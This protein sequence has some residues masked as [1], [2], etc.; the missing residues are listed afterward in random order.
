MENITKELEK[1]LCYCM[2]RTEVTRADIDA[3]C[4]TQITNHIFEMVNAVAE[5]DPA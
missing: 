1:L 4:I 3:V 5:Q 2:D